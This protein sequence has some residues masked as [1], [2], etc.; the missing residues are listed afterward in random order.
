MGW[1]FD[2]LRL[3]VG[4]VVKVLKEKLKQQLSMNMMIP[5]PFQ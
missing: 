4:A 2:S 3:V 1:I 5:L